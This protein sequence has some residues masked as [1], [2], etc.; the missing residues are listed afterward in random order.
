MCDENVVCV[1]CRGLLLL[2]VLY[3]F[4]VICSLLK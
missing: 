4:C 3:G 1:I 2:G